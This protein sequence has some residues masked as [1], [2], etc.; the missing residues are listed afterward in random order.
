MRLIERFQQGP[1]RRQGFQRQAPSQSSNSTNSVVKHLQQV[2]NHRLQPGI[3]VACSE[4]Y[5]HYQQALSLIES[6]T[7]WN[8]L[9]EY[10]QI[11]EPRL[12]AISIVPLS[13][14][15]A[16]SAQKAV[17][18]KDESGRMPV[19]LFSMI[20]RLDDTQLVIAVLKLSNGQLRL[21]ELD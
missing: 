21:I 11:M 15:E 14:N 8:H 4:Q 20:S 17:Q 1:K 3:S 9:A 5:Q 12:S 18:Q 19:G 10:L 16:H 2:L 7:S 13:E 6:E